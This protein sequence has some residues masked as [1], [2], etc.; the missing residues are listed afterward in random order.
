MVIARVARHPFLSIQPHGLT[1]QIP[2][3]I[4]EAIA[5]AT[6]KVPTLDDPAMLKIPPN[7]QSG[8]E[9]RLKG[10]GLVE[11]DGPGDLVIKIL[12]NVPESVN[13]VGIK[14]KAAGLDQYYEQN[15]RQNY[16]KSLLEC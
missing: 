9:F 8:A 2:I 16:P 15:V 12:I 3:T 10:R 14:D 7:T 11:K 4:G 5:G 6:I 13:A 1:V